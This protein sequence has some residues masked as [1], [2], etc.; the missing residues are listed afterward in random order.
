M[1]SVYKH[2]G[3]WR[4]QVHKRGKR[5]SRLF[6]TRQ[7]AKDWAARREYELDNPE[8]IIAEMPLSQVFIDYARDVSPT[9]R[10]HR[11]EVL[12]LDRLARSDLG[13]VKLGAASPRV[14]ADWRDARLK[15]AKPGT[16]IREMNLMSAVLSHARLEWELIAENPLS[17]VKRPPSPAS[18]T[19]LPTADEF[20][21]L[22][23]VAGF[24]LTTRTARAYHAFRFACETAM[25]AGEIVG[26]TWDRVDL[27]AQVASL[28]MT[29]NG[30][31][32]DVPLSSA[33]VQL[34]RDLPEMDPVFGITTRQLDA[35]WRKIRDKAG[36]EGLTFHDS[37]AYAT[38]QLAKKVNVLEL[39][40]ITGHRDIK[41]LMVYYR[42]GASDIAKRL[43]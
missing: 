39:A 17:R 10:G 25:R 1:A 33:A 29:K 32:R 35:L 38:G 15:K 40:R 41:M 22:H 6:A 21:R 14:F 28:P 9:K 27:E 3:K 43:G 36:I 18:R 24:D 12:R 37:R 13:K 30:T 8:K 19:R 7:A 31:A 16:V 2:N 4:A 34:L 26:L 20:D 11:W 42:V 23:H 5:D